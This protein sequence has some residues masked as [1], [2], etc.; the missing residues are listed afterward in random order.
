MRP[1]AIPDDLEGA[2]TD[3]TVGLIHLESSF[4]QGGRRPPPDAG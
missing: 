2:I 4:K 3:K 1:A